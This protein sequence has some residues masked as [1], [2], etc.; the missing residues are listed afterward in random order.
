MNATQYRR[1]QTIGV[2]RF[3]LRVSS[4]INGCGFSG[5]VCFPKTIEIL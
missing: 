1:K 5:L 3:F 2:E 4:V